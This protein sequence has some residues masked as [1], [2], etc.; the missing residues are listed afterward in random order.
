MITDAVEI[1]KGEIWCI[2][3]E[4]ILK[5]SDKKINEKKLFYIL[6]ST[7]EVIGIPS[8][9]DQSTSGPDTNMHTLSFNSLPLRTDWSEYIQ[10]RV[11]GNSFHDVPP[12]PL[13]NHLKWAYNEEY[14]H[15]ISRH[16]LKRIEKEGLL[17]QKKRKVAERYVMASLVANR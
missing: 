10:H 11:L 15:G 14:Y 5:T 8:T 17:G 4:P 9:C 1:V 13:I 7:C 16:W 3:A 6:E 12:S 2:T